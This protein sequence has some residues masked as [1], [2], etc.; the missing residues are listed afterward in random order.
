MPLGFGWWG[1]ALTQLVVSIEAELR[2][3]LCAQLLF[4]GV[5]AATLDAAAALDAM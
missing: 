4:R 3:V 1:Y 5:G 2:L